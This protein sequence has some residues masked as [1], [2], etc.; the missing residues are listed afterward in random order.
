MIICYVNITET[1]KIIFFFNKNKKFLEQ[2]RKKKTFHSREYFFSY[3]YFTS[4]VAFP[5]I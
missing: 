2:R 1:K 4:G 5:H 3:P